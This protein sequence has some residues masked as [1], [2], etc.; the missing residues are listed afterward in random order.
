[1]NKN[2][3]DKKDK[4][5]QKNENL[6]QSFNNAVH[7][8]LTAVNVEK[9]MK[10]HIVAAIFVIA[11]S[12]FF[13]FTRV[14][15]GMLT[16]TITMVFMAELFNTAIEEITDLASGGKY[17]KLAKNTKDIAAG[18]VFIAAINAVLV[19]YL[20]FYNRILDLSKSAYKKIWANSSHLS[21]ITIALVLVLT[22]LL[23]GIF[24]KGKGS[25]FQGGT[26][27]GHAALAFSL[28]TI[29]SFL[30][31]DARLRFMFY[32]LAFIVAESRVEAKIHSLSEVVLGA[33]V[34]LMVTLLIFMKFI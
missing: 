22:L 31:P 26:V 21:F 30:T 15:M 23:K 20:L 33:L 3:D 16:I 12:L 24:Y 13:D 25:P 4:R 9:N 1:M 11:F 5:I 32:V 34:G 2:P 8:L 29:G 18:A 28:A 6:I 27:S 19:G 7:G 17:S 10:I 14:E